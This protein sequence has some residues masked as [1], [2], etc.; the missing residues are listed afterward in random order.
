MRH[1]Y[2][3]AISILTGNFF[4]CM[5]LL[6]LLL[7]FAGLLNDF[8]VHFSPLSGRNVTQLDLIYIRQQ[9]R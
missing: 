7:L 9:S 5:F 8:R 2:P 1:G 6:L 4:V 3:H